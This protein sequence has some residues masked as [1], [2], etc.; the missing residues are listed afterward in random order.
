MIPRDC[1]ASTSPTVFR[2]QNIRPKRD[3]DRRL[4]PNLEPAP[5]RGSVFRACLLA[6]LI[7][8]YVGRTQLSLWWYRDIG[9]PGIGLSGFLKSFFCVPAGGPAICAAP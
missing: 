2:D 3:G 8:F 7:G 5:C 6:A 9:L 1:F 4:T